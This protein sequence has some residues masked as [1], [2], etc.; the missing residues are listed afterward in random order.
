MPRQLQ[1]ALPASPNGGLP[2]APS[3]N[4]SRKLALKILLGKPLF[5][6]GEKV[7][8]L[9]EVGVSSELSLG[10]IGLELS[11]FQGQSARAGRVVLCCVVV[12]ADTCVLLDEG[13]GGG[14]RENSATE[15][16]IEYGEGSWPCAGWRDG[17]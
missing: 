2:I 12:R 9:L 1:K 5:V 15:R 16:E 13:G 17:P 6:A 3:P 7:H 8:G 10:D 14:L 11:A 4:S